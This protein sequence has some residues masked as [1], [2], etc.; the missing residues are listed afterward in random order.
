MFDWL[1][2]D[3]VLFD[4]N[5]EIVKVFH[6]PSSMS[7][8]EYRFICQQILDSQEDLW[9]SSIIKWQKLPYEKKKN[10]EL[11]V[12]MEFQN[13]VDIRDG[14]LATVND[15]QGFIHIKSQFVDAIRSAE[16]K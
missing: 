5:D 7:R 4:E 11:K 8:G 13:F 1:E 2:G 10:Y 12:Q 3:L 15:Y 9:E 6:R 14:L 16:F